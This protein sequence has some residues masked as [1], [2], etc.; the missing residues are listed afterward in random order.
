MDNK[1]IYILLNNENEAKKINLTIKREKYFNKEYDIVEPCLCI[2]ITLNL[3][4][5][6]IGAPDEPLF[7]P[8]LYSI[9]Y[10]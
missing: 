9:V 10:F 8:P 7:V 5:L 3:F 2:P 1:E 6:K 4:K